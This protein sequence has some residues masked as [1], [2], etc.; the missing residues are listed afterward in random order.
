MS[1]LLYLRGYRSLAAI[2]LAGLVRMAGEF[3]AGCLLYA[4]FAQ[5][6]RLPPAFGLSLM[7]ILL[8]IGMSLPSCGL[9]MAFAF[10]LMVILAAQGRNGFARLLEWRP[11]LLLGEISFSVYMVHV[12][13]LWVFNWLGRQ[14]FPGNTGATNILVFVIIL[15]LATGMYRFIEVPARKWGRRLAL[16]ERVATGKPITVTL[17]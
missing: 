1:A 7:L 15:V 5:G 14:G 3:P 6:W 11:V 4:A 2:D 10:P 9:V 13:V 17:D 12:I 16:G 8:G